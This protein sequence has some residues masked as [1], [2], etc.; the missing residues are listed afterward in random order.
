MLSV[1]LRSDSL[2]PGC[3]L[4]VAMSTLVL[5]YPRNLWCEHA[6]GRETCRVPPAYCAIALPMWSMYPDHF[7]LAGCATLTVDLLSLVVQLG[8][9][10]YHLDVERCI[11]PV[12]RTYN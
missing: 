12:E 6:Q 8:G 5:L 4:Y 11:V 9:L 10:A 3:D 1:P 7:L 2:A